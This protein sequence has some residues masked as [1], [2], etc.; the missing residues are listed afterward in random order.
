MKTPKLIKI[1]SDKTKAKYTIKETHVAT[2]LDITLLDL[3]RQSNKDIPVINIGDEFES[4]NEPYAYFKYKGVVWPIY[5]DDAGQ[6]DCIYLN[7]EWVSGGAFC[8]YPDN[9][10]CFIFQID[11]ARENKK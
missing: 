1:K 11:N 2:E 5:D 4:I 7:N 8:C 10:E 6:C 9:V 3:Y